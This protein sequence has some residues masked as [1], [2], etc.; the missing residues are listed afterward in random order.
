MNQLD[1]Q[2]WTLVGIEA[3]FEIAARSLGKNLKPLPQARKWLSCS[4]T[5]TGDEYRQITFGHI[6]K[7]I[8]DKW[9]IFFENDKIYFHHSS[10]G[11]LI[12]EVELRAAGKLYLVDS[13]WVNRDP[14]QN[15]ETDD[16][17]ELETLSSLIDSLL[18]PKR[19]PS[20]NPY[21]SILND[22]QKAKPYIEFDTAGKKANIFAGL[23]RISASLETSRWEIKFSNFKEESNTCSENDLKSLKGAIIEKLERVTRFELRGAKLKLY[24]KDNLLLTFENKSLSLNN[25]RKY[26]DDSHYE[27]EYA[28]LISL[29]LEDDGSFSYDE[30]WSCYGASTGGTANGVWWQSGDLLSFRCDYASGSFT[31][32]WC[33]GCTLTATEKDGVLDFFNYFTMTRVSE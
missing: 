4:R 26:F 3:K 29:T 10:T 23:D 24:E 17:F 8:E 18:L 19:K 9:F 16:D 1:L 6:P 32:Q 12:Y 28:I 11:F 14:S 2:K 22:E 7:E 20:L 5:F 13:V 27:Q 30:S 33:E 25:P 15:S 31:L 21:D